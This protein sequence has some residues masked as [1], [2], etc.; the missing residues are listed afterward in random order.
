MAKLDMKWQQYR[1]DGLVRAYDIVCRQGIEGLEKEIRFRKACPM[2]LE[3]DRET[4]DKI[5][6]GILNK[7][8]ATYVTVVFQTLH[9]VFGLGEIRLKRFK[10]QFDKQVE[11]IHTI[12]EFG[13]RYDDFVTLAQ[14]LNDKYHLDIDMKLVEEVQTSNDRATDTRASLA[15]IYHLLKLYGHED[16]AEWLK[17]FFE[18]EKEIEDAERKLSELPEVLEIDAV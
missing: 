2:Q 6:D 14:N 10:K 11:W 12:D 7:V 13:F 15:S 5:F 9:D 1:N 16:A 18:I 17:G 3:I 8:Y 4:A